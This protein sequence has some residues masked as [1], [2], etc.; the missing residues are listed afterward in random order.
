MVSAVEYYTAERIQK[1]MICCPFHKEKTASMRI[2]EDGFYCFGCGRGGDVINFIAYI[3]NVTNKNAVEKID[4]D[5]NLGLT[6]AEYDPVAE[7]KREYE[8]K[9][10]DDA[11]AWKKR[12]LIKLCKSRFAWWCIGNS[13]DYTKYTAEETALASANC[14]FLDY[15]TEMLAESEKPDRKEIEDIARRFYREAQ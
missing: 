14:N 7:M 6:S 5:F 3:Y 11:E 4:A 2:Y 10:R 9:K 12:M 15:V 1:G 8:R 13:R